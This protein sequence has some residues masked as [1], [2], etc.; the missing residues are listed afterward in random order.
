MIF[1]L[2]NQPAIGYPHDAA[3]KHQPDVLLMKKMPTLSQLETLRSVEDAEES[4]EVIPNRW[5]VYQKHGKN[6]L[7]YGGFIGVPPFQETSI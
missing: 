4:E 2:I 3:G 7:K 1:H 6:I 5:L